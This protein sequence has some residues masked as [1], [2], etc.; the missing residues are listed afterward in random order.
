MAGEKFNISRQTVNTHLSRLRAEGVLT[1][2]GKTS[3]KRYGLRILQDW[4]KGYSLEPGLTEDA[5]WEEVA[6]VIAELPANVLSIWNTG[7]TEMFNNAL[8]HSAGTYVSVRVRKTAINTEVAIFDDGIGIFRK[9]QQALS[10]P[11]E[12]HAILELSKGKFTTDPSKHSGEGIFFTS[13]MF[14]KFDILSGGLYFT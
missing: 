13:R 9:I 14:D 8:D 4:D 3:N 7:F 11:D 6:P 10:L 5:A 12:R 2:T 1:E